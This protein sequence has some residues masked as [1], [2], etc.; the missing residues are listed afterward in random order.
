MSRKTSGKLRED[1]RHETTT[2]IPST[3]A[4]REHTIAINTRQRVATRITSTIHIA[5]RITA[6]GEKASHK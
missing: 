2:R 6:A 5:T 1:E 3:A 4:V